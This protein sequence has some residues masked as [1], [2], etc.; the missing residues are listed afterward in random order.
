M[1]QYFPKPFRNF[2]RN[3][4]VKVDLSNYA[5]KTDLKNVTHVDTSS[6]ALKTNLV[7]LKTEVDKLDI[8]KLVPV[9]VDLSKLS[10]V[11]KYHVVKKAV[12]VKLVAKVNNI[13]TSDFML[14][15][16][17]HTDKTKLEKKILDVSNLVKKAKLTELENKIPDVSSL[18]TK[19]A[20]TAVENKLPSVSNFAKKTDLNKKIIEIEN[21]LNNYNHDKSIT[22]PEFNTL[23]AVFTAILAQANLTT[24]TDFDAKLSSLNWKIAANKAKKLLAENK[25]SKLKTF[26]SSYFIGK[27][28]FEEDGTQNYL[29]L[30]P[31]NK[32]FKVISNDDYVSSWKSK[33]L[34]A[35][36][37]KPPT[38]PD[39]SLTP[40]VN[41]Y[42]TKTRVK[43]TGCSLKQPKFPYTQEKVVNIYIVY[44]LDASSSHILILILISHINPTLKIFY[45]VSATLTKNAD[46]DKHGYSGYGNGFDRRSGFSFSVV[47]LVKMY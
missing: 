35:E 40:A 18:A 38:T 24:K 3:I 14:K 32:Y 31:I 16:K 45:L 12:Y 41:Y 8:D 11:V 13:D 1:S 37:I 28:H 42:G 17:Y 4:N 30:Q 22:T 36:T 46:I 26:N 25:L 47:D 9:P 19:T 21:K 2:G 20:V 29:V 10:D 39:N 44:E 43:F 7:N 27:S 33:G 6:F 34:S 5:T 15:T 23:A